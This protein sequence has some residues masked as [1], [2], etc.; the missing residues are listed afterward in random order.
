MVGTQGQ[1]ESRL[2]VS[3]P[4]STLSPIDRVVGDKL[5]N[6]LMANTV[7]RLSTRTLYFDCTGSWR[8]VLMTIQQVILLVLL[9]VQAEIVLGSRS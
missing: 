3:H 5:I 2:L 6:R 7:E 4:N 9:M 1:Q 8:L